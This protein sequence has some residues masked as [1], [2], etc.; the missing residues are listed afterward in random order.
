MQNRTDPADHEQL[1][2]WL[3]LEREPGALLSRQERRRLEEHVSSC[4]SCRAERR[5]LLHLDALLVDN[6]VPVRAGFADDVLR[7]LPAAGWESRSVRAWRLPL[8]A[9]LVLGLG[10]AA[11]AGLGATGAGAAGALSGAAAALLDMVVTGVL[12]ATGMLWAS[13]RGLGL[14]IDAY[15]SPGT[16]VALFILVVSLDV[17]LLTFL[18]RRSRR[19]PE[20]AADGARRPLSGPS[21][22]PGRRS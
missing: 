10:A 21:R 17:L 16:A 7:A 2:E 8:A 19:G 12:A 4:A 6:A 14:A 22:R 11:V 15:L 20:P 3:T 5:E 9:L 18:V 1:R 13:W